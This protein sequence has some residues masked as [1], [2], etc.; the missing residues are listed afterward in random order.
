MMVGS[1]T[2]CSHVIL[3]ECPSGQ[4]V[5]AVDFLVPILWRFHYPFIV[6]VG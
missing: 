5:N 4:I 1:I 2:F 3:S 6:E